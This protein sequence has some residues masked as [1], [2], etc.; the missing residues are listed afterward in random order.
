[1]TPKQREFYD[2]FEAAALLELEDSWLDGTLPGVNLIRCRQLM[3]HP[4]TF[5]PPLDVI[6]LTGKEER[7]L[8]H[9]E[10]H[11]N[12]PLVIFGAL[13]EQHNR[14]VEICKAEGFRVGLINGTVSGAQR[15]RVDLAF[16]AGELDIVVASP[17]TAGIGFNWGHVDHIIFMSLDYMDSN[18][19]QAYRRA[20]RGKREKPLLITVMEY[21]NSVDQKI[22]AIVEKKSVM[23][24]EVDPT[25]TAV[26]LR[27]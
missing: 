27:C 23:A 25:R 18:F 14:V 2:E 19:V 8:I 13:T 3:E 16:Q 4:Q 26:R 5:G 11:R 20:I 12:K 7:L 10:D 9:L 15:S 6:K 1:M 17:A 21:E 22:F 24:Q